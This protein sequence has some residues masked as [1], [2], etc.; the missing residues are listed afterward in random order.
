MILLLY[1]SFLLVKAINTFAFVVL[2]Y[3]MW[4][5]HDWFIDDLDKQLVGEPRKIVEENGGLH[6]SE[7]ATLMYLSFSMGGKGFKPI[8][9]L[10]VHTT[11]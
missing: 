8:E 4:K 3:P 9:I 5:A 6:T 1:L 2:T 10:K 11:F 7:L